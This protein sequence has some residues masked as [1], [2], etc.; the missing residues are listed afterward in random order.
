MISA[1]N[2]PSNSTRAPTNLLLSACDIKDLASDIKDQVAPEFNNTKAERLFTRND[3]K[4]KHINISR[5]ININNEIR[6]RYIPFT[7]SGVA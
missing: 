4:I 2:G 3:P 5:Q 7:M 1:S 6:R